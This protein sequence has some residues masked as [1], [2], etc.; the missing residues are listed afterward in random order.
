M[1]PARPPPIAHGVAGPLRRDHHDVEIGARLDQVEVDVEPVGEHQ[2]RAVFH[3]GVQL[4]VIDVGLQ[5]VGRQHHHH[6]GPFG[7]LGDFHH[8]ELLTLR[9]LHALRTLAQRDR[10]VLD[11]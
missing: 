1:M 7:G 8:L 10:D 5:L 6:V 9:L 2:R 11:A 3:V 4:A